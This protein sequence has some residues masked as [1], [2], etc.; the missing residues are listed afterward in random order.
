MAPLNIFKFYREAYSAVTDFAFYRSVFLQP[1]RRTLLYL[2]FLSANAS[3]ILT[4]AYAWHY[5]PR[6]ERF[7]DWAQDNFPPFEVSNG[8]L[9]VQGEEPIVHRYQDD[10]VVTFIFDTTGEYGLP[11]RSQEP[12][13][14]LAADRLYLR[15][16]GVNQTYE[17]QDLGDFSKSQ[18]PEIRSFIQWV[19][20]PIGYSFWLIYTL[21]TKSML[22]LFLTVFGLSASM[23][24]GIRLPFAHYFTIGIYSL[25]PAVVIDLAVTV[26]GQNVPYFFMIYFAAAALYTYMATHKCTVI[27]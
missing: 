9:A 3:I 4:L 11:R 6:L 21:A 13:V 15:L 1:I 26:I 16:D 20:F 14:L 7:F 24:T 25:T 2:M 23:R 5:G 8:Q 12:A 17:W 19:Y 18:L 10:Q 22:V 27:E